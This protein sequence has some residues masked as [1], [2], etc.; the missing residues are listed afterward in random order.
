[1][2]VYFIALAILIAIF[3]LVTKFKKE[4]ASQLVFL[5]L[6]GMAISTTILFPLILSTIDN[7]NEVFADSD[8][9]ENI[10]ADYLGE[11]KESFILEYEDSPRNSYYNLKHEGKDFTV[12]LDGK[13]V[14]KLVE[15]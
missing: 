3:I 6:L 14:I 9:A 8:Q 11:S 1:M 5:T 12:I 7:F 4:T 10:V 13:E 2:I 15:K